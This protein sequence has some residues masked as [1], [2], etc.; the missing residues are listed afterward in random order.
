MPKTKTKEIKTLK[1]LTPDPQNINKGTQ[2]G[3]SAL[4]HS[5]RKF[6]IGRGIVAD[7]NGVIVGGNKTVERLAD[8]GLTKIKVVHTT[9]DELVVNVRDDLDLLSKKDRRARGLALADNQ[10][11]KLSYDEDTEALAALAKGER[12]LLEGLWNDNEINEIL[13]SGESPEFK[14]YDESIANG[15]S[16]CKCPTCG[17]EHAKKD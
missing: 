12:E 17:H 3:L 10:V 6:G 1:D 9:G 15:V 8:L 4:D 13:N 11:G 16:V 7:K 14:E 2:R 5:V